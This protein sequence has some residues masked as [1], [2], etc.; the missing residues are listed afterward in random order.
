MKSDSATPPTDSLSKV[1]DD[2][3]ISVPTELRAGVQAHWPAIRSALSGV[4][5]DERSRAWAVSLPRVLACSDFM[6]QA[7]ERDAAIFR[8]LLKSGDLFRPYSAGQ[9]AERVHQA[10]ARASDEAD[11]KRT[12]RIARRQ[13]MIRLA[14]RDLAA[15]APLDEVLATLSEF[16]DACIGAALRWL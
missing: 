5:V 12:L 9:L 16:A 1:A 3:L 6:L 2:A 15:Q 8:E 7:L 10:V 14:W 11:L 4:R 13:E